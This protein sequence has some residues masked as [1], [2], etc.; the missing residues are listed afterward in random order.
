[1]AS[2]PTR[3]SRMTTSRWTRSG[4]LHTRLVRRNVPVKNLQTRRD[5]ARGR[6]GVSPR[7]LAAAGDPVRGCPRIVK[8]L[9]DK[10]LMKVQAAIQVTRSGLRASERRSAGSHAPAPGTRLRRRAEF[11]NYR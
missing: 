5:R 11:R 2:I 3:S 4:N 10:K 7:H 6:S 1:V 9:K 8:F